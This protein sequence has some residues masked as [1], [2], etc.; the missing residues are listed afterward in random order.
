MADSDNYQ[1]EIY[2]CLTFRPSGATGPAGSANISGSANYL[3]KF[4]GATSGG[5][6]I[7]YENAGNVGIGSTS[8]T[9][10]LEVNGTT[11]LTLGDVTM[12]T[13]PDN[14][15][16]IIGVCGTIYGNGKFAIT[17][18]QDAALF[19]DDPTASFGALYVNGDVL[20]MEYLS[21]NSAKFIERYRCHFYFR[22]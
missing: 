17:S 6:S 20:I 5:N 19:V 16:G 7:I 8:P 12:C 18:D 11:N 9:T 21:A 10:T 4:T 14:T 15:T 13:T 22:R 3:V 1:L 2:F